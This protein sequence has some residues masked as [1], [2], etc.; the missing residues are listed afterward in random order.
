MSSEEIIR[1]KHYIDIKHHNFDRQ[2]RASVLANAVHRI[3]DSRLPSVPDVL[4]REIRSKLLMNKRELLSIDVDDVLQQCMSLDLSREDILFPLAAWV[5]SK[6]ANSTLEEEVR[7]IILGWSMEDKP[8]VGFQALE[9]K[10]SS[11]DCIPCMELA[12]THESVVSTPRK[13]WLNR[14]RYIAGATV[15][16]AAILMTI[17][18]VTITLVNQ[19]PAALAPTINTTNLSQPVVSEIEKSDSFGIPKEFRYVS[20]DTKRLQNYLLE[21]NSILAEEPF[22]SAI[23]SAGKQ[24]DIHPLLLFAITGQEQGFVSKNHKDV[25][26]IAN[27]PFNV[28][29]SWELY[30]TTIK[31]SAEIAAKTVA[32]ISSRRPEGRHPVQWLNE[33]YAEDPNWWMGVTW[34]FNKL[35]QDV[36]DDTF[37]W[38]E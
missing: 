34:F 31:S 28:F 29:G 7:Q 21:K 1:L 5:C 3:I 13:G 23:I 37:E 8:L 26:K 9:S 4:K 30:N 17:T 22:I 38:S 16:A 11:I 35:Q 24:Y 33:T 12:A 2:Q 36:Q 19:Q 14:K 20:V 25:E 15:F 27:N 32:N 10:L 18:L 6:T